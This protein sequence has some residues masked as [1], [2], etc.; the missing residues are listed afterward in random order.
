[1]DH[2]CV[3]VP[4]LGGFVTQYVSAHRVESEELFLPPYRSVGFNAQLTLNDG[5]LVQSYMKAYGASYVSAV[6]LIKN[7]VSR[8]KAQLSAEG[9]FTLSGIGTLSLGVGWNYTFAPCEAGVASPELYGLD[10]LTLPLLP[11][12]RH[13]SRLAW[14]RGETRSGAGEEAAEKSYT[15]RINREVVNY[16]AAAVIALVFYF[17]WATPISSPSQQTALEASSAYEQLFK[18]TSTSATKKT[19]ATPKPESPK[20]AQTAPAAPEPAKTADGTEA[21]ELA[22]YYTLVLASSITR[23]NAR[24]YVSEL[25][26]AGLDEARVYEHRRMVRVICGKYQ[27]EVDARKALRRISK[28]E[29]VA[30]AWVLKVKE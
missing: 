27:T 14:L 7:A 6:R 8:V 2:D 10:S 11:A 5:L 18:S 15:I 24:I 16:A 22:E 12:A 20:T 17:V 19:A 29:G 3:I 1:L 30:D 4:G 13:T 26:A 9:S 23:R 25:R 21:A 28:T